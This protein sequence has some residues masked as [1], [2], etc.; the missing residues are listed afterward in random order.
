MNTKH[1]KHT[2]FLSLSLS[3]SVTQKKQWE[4]AERNRGRQNHFVVFGPRSTKACVGDKS[5]RQ[6]ETDR[7]KWG[8]DNASDTRGLGKGRW[9]YCR[10]KHTLTNT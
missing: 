7:E 6:N 5:L 3:N 8:M 2:E 9:T 1:Y 4:R 10:T